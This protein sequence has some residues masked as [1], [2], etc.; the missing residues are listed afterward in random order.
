MTRTLEE[1]RSRQDLNNP[2]TIVCGIL[3]PS[4]SALP[5]GSSY[6]QQTFE[7]KL[8]GIS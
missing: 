2:R 3:H 5:Y 6:P 4:E 1:T 7:R 8:S